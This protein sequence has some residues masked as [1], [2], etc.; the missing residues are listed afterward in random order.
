MYLIEC[1][2]A[3][4]VILDFVRRIGDGGKRYRQ[5]A[6]YRVAVDGG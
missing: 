2:L 5:K 3:V 6:D 1:E 4:F